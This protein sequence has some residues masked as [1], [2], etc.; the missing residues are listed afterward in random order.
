[1][2]GLNLVIPL[3][4]YL[5]CIELKVIKDKYLLLFELLKNGQPISNLYSG[6]IISKLSCDN[7]KDVVLGPRG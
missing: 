2:I 5:S 1:M 4:D 6:E 3:P 7:D